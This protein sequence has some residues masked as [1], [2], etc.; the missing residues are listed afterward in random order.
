MQDI[1]F[2]CPLNG[3][4]FGQVSIGLLRE[5]YR[6]EM[7]VL[8]GCI[9]GQPD[10]KSQDISNEFANWLN[11]ASLDF[12]KKHNHD[13]PTFKLWHINGAMDKV[14]NN[15]ALMSFY[16]L[17]DPTD[18]EINIAKNNKKLIFSSNYTVDIFKSRDVDSHYVPLFFDKDNFKVI[19]REYYDDNRVV[20]NL[21]GKFEHRKR[22]AK[23]IQS[24]IKKYG[25]NKKYM[26]QC[27]VFNPFLDEK[28]NNEIVTELLQGER[29]WNVVFN[30][31]FPKNEQYNS[32]LN[33]ADVI[34]GMSGGEG[35]GL[36]EFQSVALGKH[37]VILNAHA[38]KE[39]ANEENSVLVEAT[40]KT[41]CYDN[42]FFR[43]G[44]AFNQG[45]I[46]DWDEDDF[47]SGC[48][49]ATKR[50]HSDRKNHEGLKLQ[51]EYTAGR[52]LDKIIEVL[53]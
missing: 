20:F 25:N 33:S 31:Q 24:W 49:E 32:Y 46:F 47:I 7:N 35:W 2:N 53:S 5:A 37:S 41:D 18:A 27:S 48:E 6:R 39:W 22:H 29:Y 11:K 26:L 15:Q 17:D 8:I 51:E 12:I 38:Y 23:I 28:T 44:E 1:T 13:R 43:K 16:E 4:S 52:T 9:G 19:D 36:P 3:V 10:L 45:Q 30:P 21:C 34:I 42:V 50:V 14:S 40:K